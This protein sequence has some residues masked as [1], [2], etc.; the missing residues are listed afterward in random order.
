MFISSH[1]TKIKPDQDTIKNLELNVPLLEIS[2]YFK[3]KNLFQTG[4][5]GC[6]TSLLKYFSKYFPTKLLIDFTIP[7]T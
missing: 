2:V 5:P 4:A 1:C 7:R 3:Q 6:N